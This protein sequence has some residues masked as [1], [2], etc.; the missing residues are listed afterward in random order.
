VHRRDRVGGRG[1]P[2]ADDKREPFGLHPQL[3][4]IGLVD[5]PQNLADVLVAQSHP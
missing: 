1:L 2:L 3:V 5:D 4:Q